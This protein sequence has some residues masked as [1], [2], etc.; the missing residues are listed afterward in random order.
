MQSKQELSWDLKIHIA[1]GVA[2]GLG[3]LHSI[4]I[5]HRDIKSENFLV[6]DAWQIKVCDL[7]FARKVDSLSR[8]RSMSICGTEEYMSPEMLVG[9]DYNEKVDVFSYGIFLAELI[10]LCYLPTDFKRTAA[11]QFGIDIIKFKDLIPDDCPAQLADLVIDCC[12]FSSYSR[13]SFEKVVHR[14]ADIQVLL[15]RFYI[16][17][18]TRTFDYFEEIL[19]GSTEGS[20]RRPR[21]GVEEIKFKEYLVDEAAFGELEEIKFEELQLE[22]IK[23]QEV[24]FL[25]VEETEPFSSESST[26]GTSNLSSGISTIETPMIKPIFSS[27]S[28]YNA[29]G[30]ESEKSTDFEN[31]SDSEDG[32]ID[33]L[34][35]EE[36]SMVNLKVVEI[37][38]GNEF[39]NS[40][41][42]NNEFDSNVVTRNKK[43]SYYYN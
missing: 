29:R 12:S 17:P 13:P 6:G 14:L 5:L 24:D 43:Y 9:L 18:A 31:S 21:A 38:N 36:V 3:Y 27:F 40:E 1:I 8:K 7:G 15:P 39:K 2:Q 28:S 4:N 35:M 20:C 33:Y 19:V 22:E 25:D 32:E 41:L 37:P 34:E 11:T 42:V 16:R 26:E 30:F 23:L 10:S